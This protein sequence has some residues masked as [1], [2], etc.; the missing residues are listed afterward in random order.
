[1]QPHPQ[2]EIQSLPVRN[3]LRRA[4]TVVRQD[5]RAYIT[6][7]CIY[8][9]LVALGMIYVAFINPELQNNLI[10]AVGQSF[11]QGPLA[12]VGSAYSGGKVASA[13][14]LTFVVNLLL[15]SVIQISLPSL[16]IPFSGLLMGV[17]RA[18]L[19]G[20][21]LSPS[22]TSLAGPMIPHSLVLLLEG[23]A[24]ILVMLSVFVQG[25]AFVRP[26]AYQIDGHLRGYLEGLRRAG[27]IYLLVVLTLAGAAIYEA[28]EVIYLA[29]LFV[30]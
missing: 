15:G 2:N 25:K 16:I 24:Y 27:W 10:K 14:L 20:L 17:V 4:W 12:S 11:T 26:Q 21:L 29:P 28:L 5:W 6:L 1:M 3:P 23:Q 9:G 19:W 8:Y 18:C 13:M 30:H 22:N 7:N